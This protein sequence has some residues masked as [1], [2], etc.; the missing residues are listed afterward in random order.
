MT[1]SRHPALTLDPVEAAESVDVESDMRSIGETARE[2]GL[3]VSALRFY[4]GAGV[5]CP[6][7]V[8]PQTGYRWYRTD[9]LADARLLCRLRR[10]GLPVAEIRL[11]LAAPPGSGEAHRVL[12]RHLRRLEDGLSDARRELSAVRTLIDQRESPMSSSTTR[13]AATRLTVGAADLAAALDAVRFAAAEDSEH[14]VLGGVLFDVEGSVLRV[15]ATDRY[16]MA[17]SQAAVPALEGPGA[18]TVVPVPVVDGI[19]ALLAGG[20]EVTLTLDGDRVVLEAAAGRRLEGAALEGDFPDYRRLTRIE[21]SHRTDV[22]ASV[23]REAVAGGACRTVHEGHEIVLLSVGPGGAVGVVT[24]DGGTGGDGRG[25]A[26]GTRIAVN[27]QYLLEAIGAGAPE[28]LVLETGS[29]ITP[30]AI[31]DAGN[32]GTFSILMP[33]RLP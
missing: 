19:R 26:D 32:D 33:V 13:T 4:D 21:A 15:V 22:P 17:V 24:E 9:Q 27:R 3:T 14:P 31:R 1:V 29:P 28:Q 11:V 30:L 25:P 5:F 18:S 6:A 7:W 12:D 16:R 8:D 23:L 2:S 10:V 20:G